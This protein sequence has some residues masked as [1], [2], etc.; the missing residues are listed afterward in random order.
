[1][2]TKG[3]QARRS[4]KWLQAWAAVVAGLLIL[5]GAASPALASRG[6]VSFFGSQSAE[7]AFGGTFNSP[8]GV[9]VNQT[10]GDIYVA[11]SG[12]NRIQ[13]FDSSGAFISAWGR[14]VIQSGKSGDLGDAYEIC[15][16]ASDC[17]AG[18]RGTLADGPGGEVAIPQ[19]VAVN[20]TT[21][22]IYVTEQSNR[23]VSEFTASG[24]F[25]RTFGWDVETGGATTFEVCTV[26]ANCK[27]GASGG[28]G[29]EFGGIEL[30]GITIGP[31]GAVY[32][33]DPFNRRYEE[34]TAEGVFAAAVGWDVVPSGKPGDTGTSLERCP[35][36]ASATEGDC[37][38]GASGSGLGEFSEDEPT[39]LAVDSGG[40]VYAVES[41]GNERLQRFNAAATSASVFAGSVL[42]GFP[43]PTEVA[44]D[45]ET[46]HVLVAK[47]CTP[48]TCP[49]A[50]VGSEL[51]IKELESS[52]ALLDTDLVGE[53]L[54]TINGLAA[55]SSNGTL[56]A[57]S[58]DQH[59]YVISTPPPP[60]VTMGSIE[61]ITGTS[62]E[63]NGEVNPTGLDTGYHFEYRPDGS[64]IWTK[65]PMTDAGAGNGN[66]AVPVAQNV[67]GLV[68]S[69]LY[70]VRLVATKRYLLGHTVAAVATSTETTF[71]TLPS[72]PRIEAE[73]A[74]QITN[75]TATLTASIN[76]AHESTAYR[77]EYGTADCSLNLCT[78]VPIPDV[79]I[80]AGD[81]DVAVAQELTGLQP[82]IE[83]HFRVV[84][85]NPTGVSAGEDKSFT[86]YPTA[87]KGLP[88]ERAYELVTPAD[89][90]GLFPRSFIGAGGGRN[91]FATP[92]AASSGESV[93][94]DTEGGLPGTEGNGS[95]D[96]YE[97]V[98]GSS[99]WNTNVV[100]P[101]GAQAE[102]PGP[103][104]LSANQA[105]AFWES[106]NFGNLAL[107]GL[108]TSYLRL[109]DGS[110][111]L[112]GKGS[113]GT[114][115]A[116]DA[117]LITPGAGHIVFATG[118][119]TPAVQLEPDA[120]EAPLGAVY[121]RTPGGAQVVSLLPGDITPAATAVYQGASADGSVIAFMVEGTLYARL[122]GT[123]TVEVASSNPRFAG[124]SQDG[125]TIFYFRPDGSENPVRGDIFA[126]DTSTEATTPIATGGGSTVVN[127]SAD[128][129][130]VYF[131]STQQLDG[132]EGTP[133]ANN[134]YVWDGST[135]RFIS[136]LAASDLTA[137]DPNGLVNLATWTT[138]ASGNALDENHGPAD[139]PSR[140]IPDGN[141][142]VFQSHASLTP[143]DSD[144][145]SEIYLY[146]AGDESLICVSCNPTGAS[147]VSDA[148]L[149]GFRGGAPTNALS[150]IP[151]V[152][153]DGRT[154][155]FQSREA[156]VPGDGDG[157]TDVYE[158][159]EGTLSLISSGHS[160]GTPDFLY[161][162]TPDGHDVFFQTRDALL[163]EDHSGG[164]GAI[165]D[166]RVGGGFP[167]VQ[168]GAPCIAE[169]SC[170][171]TP[172][173]PPALS[174]PGSE[175]LQ[176]A[177][178]TRP[179]RC[180]RGAHRVKRHGRIRCVK[181]HKR[182]GSRRSQGGPR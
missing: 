127:V 159:R 135:T 170:Q 180:H 123:A 97:A 14:D 148:E 52:G 92:L 132:A 121:D 78:S 161:G 107:G 36:S 128:G 130:H 26:A 66:V 21:G 80:G 25:L 105:Y 118:V 165:Y 50:A 51:R 131:V 133:G 23:R 39:H 15:T 124:V 117:K 171:G 9:A 139:D 166:A 103:G 82:A 138:Y 56:Y 153:S 162:M 46:G 41:T 49:D 178:P 156:L 27:R 157:A 101:S 86:T 34:F 100:S 155:F 176:S 115:P 62:A 72:S 158:W 12:N 84:A 116:A 33:A 18:S 168:G 29:G 181:K 145:H 175:S 95:V 113:M 19:G 47:P 90:N 114:D 45:P 35:A 32:V 58:Q 40:A 112:F 22:D 6:V 1:M 11:D 126:F 88:D 102:A 182:R 137:F 31:G 5:L 120:P 152:T 122:D 134:L 4:I 141:T 94:F 173:P 64:S 43:G 89:T 136:T 109:P 69:T 67:S 44:I 73:A 77:F 154:V 106:G 60:I 99:G 7:P 38:A 179:H 55:S 13:R 59:I 30:G 42:S 174:A 144:G 167:A 125:E 37:Q 108:D 65:M 143:Y 16:I 75:T 147:A 10:T 91:N 119:F 63:F 17:K 71:T 98:R 172:S 96:A 87:F 164:A 85:T 142:M 70:H 160:D 76:P 24:T 129:S 150:Q 3:G 54:E 146:D 61:G 110:F 169:D 177:V 104:G 74:T 163:P 140:T 151:N 149:Q 111:E 8:R 48:E 93:I 81:D 83:Y 79:S 57:S 53:G 68:G 28:G 2:R 20:Q